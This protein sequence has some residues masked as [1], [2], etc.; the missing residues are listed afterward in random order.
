MKTK[1]E[2]M[3]SPVVC[4]HCGEIYDLRAVK[5]I[6]RYADCSLYQT[7]CCGRTADDRTWKGLP[8]FSKWTPEMNH[9]NCYP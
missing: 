5:V 7:P 6:H 9:C 4:A 8:D 2:E 3:G 1:P